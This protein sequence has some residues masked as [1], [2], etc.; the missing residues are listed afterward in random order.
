MGFT[1]NPKDAIELLERWGDFVVETEEGEKKLFKNHVAVVANRKTL[2]RFEPNPNAHGLPP[3]QMF[4]LQPEPA[5]TYGKGVLEP[6]LGIQD[7]INV[8]L[9]QV[10]EANA[11]VVNPQYLVRN[12]G[13]ID[14]DSFISAPGAL[15]MVNDVNTSIA[16]LATPSNASLGFQEI[17]FLLAQFNEATNAMKAFTTADYQKSATEV[18]AMQ[19]MA[20]SRFA[21]MV[22]H[23]ERTFVMIALRMQ[24]QLNQQFMDEAMWIRVVNP[25]NVPPALDQF[26]QPKPVPAWDFVDANGRMK[27]DPEQIQGEYDIYPMGA[28][29][30]SNNQAAVGMFIQGLQTLGA[31]PAAQEHIKW[32]NVAQFF[33]QMSRIP[34]SWK[35]IKSQQE[36]Y[37]D[38]FQ[39][40]QQQLAMAA[41]QQ[42][43]GLGP[44][45]AGN[46]TPQQG[47]KGIGDMA[48]TPSGPSMPTS[49]GG[50]QS[51]GGPQTM[52]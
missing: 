9:N 48:G 50:Q 13:T 44:G 33:F 25:T 15:H 38:R 45:G 34:Q 42:A 8:R 41:Q 23:I 20:N 22:K 46:D 2:I 31:I 35:L 29:W 4:V 40:Q 21:Q 51:A 37:F 30:I 17:G 12:D 32:D 3:H 52:G 18:A 16:P 47:G 36:V 19:G 7:A 39:Q 14:I 6:A 26:G 10:I 1:D 24:I 27:V 5:E 11:L 49:P 43:L 28:Q